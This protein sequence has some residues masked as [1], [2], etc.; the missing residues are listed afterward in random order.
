MGISGN[1][2]TNNGVLKMSASGTGQS[3]LLLSFAVQTIGGNGEIILE[4][5]DPGA[6]ARMEVLAGDEIT[7]GSNGVI[8]GAGTIRARLTNQGTVKADQNLEK[9]TIFDETW[10]NEG[11]IEA[12]SRGIVVFD[13]AGVYQLGTPAGCLLAADGEIHFIN[14]ADISGELRSEALGR[15]VVPEG[16]ARFYEVVI[17]PGTLVNVRGT[18]VRAGYGNTVTIAGSQLL[19]HGTILVNDQASAEASLFFSAN[20]NLSGTGEIVLNDNG[21]AATA[22]IVTDPSVIVTHTAG[23]MIR[24]CGSVE[25]NMLNA[26]TIKADNPVGTLSIIPETLV[27]NFGWIEIANGCVMEIFATSS[28]VNHAEG[29]IRA[30]GDLYFFDANPD[31]NAGIISGT[32]T[33]LAPASVTNTNATFQ[34]G[35]PIGTLQI[36]GNYTQS[37]TAVLEI[38]IAGANS[39]QVDKLV[40]L[41]SVTVGGTVAV[42][43]TQG[44]LMSPGQTYE[45]LSATTLLPSLLHVLSSS[46]GDQLHRI[47]AGQQHCAHRS[48]AGRV[49]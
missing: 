26:G 41:G 28:F 17:D 8:R 6:E 4:Q 45:V 36:Q 23:H 24:G 31:F 21:G 15:F 33:L 16:N 30:D 44:F 20:T 38:E 27:E 35:S 7:L 34:P 3:T 12:R 32:G 11:I 5:L 40:V 42:N 39:A 48:N 49:A 46:T 1:T 14:N 19:N 47:H 22:A 9:L 18:T 43:T 29:R 25:G 13:S 37:G 10:T 2:L